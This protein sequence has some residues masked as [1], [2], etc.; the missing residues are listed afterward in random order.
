[1]IRIEYRNVVPLAGFDTSL[2]ARWGYRPLKVRDFAFGTS[3][4][5]DLP[6]APR[7]SVPIL[8]FW[9]KTTK[10]RIVGRKF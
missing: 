4:L 8:R 3:R 6:P 9:L 10:M 7:R 1:M 2:T 5:F